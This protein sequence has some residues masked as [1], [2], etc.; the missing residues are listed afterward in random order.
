MSTPQQNPY[1]YLPL[2]SPT[3]IRVIRLDPSDDPDGPLSL[4]LE[5][6]DINS[7]PVYEAVSYTWEGQEADRLISCH[8]RGLMITANCEIMLRRLRLTSSGGVKSLW[9]DAI[10]IDQTSI[11]EKNQQV[12]LMGQ[13][14]EVAVQVNIW[15]GNGTTET[16]A[17]LDYL[18]IVRELT[19]GDPDEYT[20]QQLEGA[21]EEL[22]GCCAAPRAHPLR[23]Q[24]RNRSDLEL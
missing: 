23:S 24:A 5:E 12:P 13:I 10:C 22:K 20:A 6:V 9:I 18:S 8:G 21:R 4:T 14:Y 7:N 11:P 1:T 3:S 2:W 19:R 16:D 17:A 15:I